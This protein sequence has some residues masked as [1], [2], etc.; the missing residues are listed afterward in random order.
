MS[1]P[2]ST[3]RAYL[4]VAPVKETNLDSASPDSTF[5]VETVPIDLVNLKEG[6]I[7]VK[8]LFFSND[9][10]Q[11]GFIQKGLK[12]EDTYAIPIREGQTMSTYGLFE[13]VSSKSDKFQVGELVYGNAFWS[14]YSVISEA[15]VFNKVDPNAGL[16]L[17]YFM[18]IVGLTGLTAYFGLLKVGKITS[19]DTV[20]ISAASGATGSNAV[21]FAKKIFGAKKVVGITGTDEK[22]RAVEALGADVGLNYNDKDFAEKLAAATDKKI[23]LYYDNVGGSILNT[24]LRS[25]SMWG[26]V[27][28][29]GSIAAYNDTSANVFSNWGAVTVKRLTVTGFIVI[30]FKENFGEAIQAIIGG[31]KAGTIKYEHGKPID[32]VGHFE[33]VPETW[34]LLFDSSKKPFGKLISKIAEL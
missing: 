7:G 19:E 5:K 14:E 9:P 27:V 20:V 8:S 11:R 18:D 4:A 33:K 12:P 31:L 25:M 16:P 22:A 1:L 15:S 34:G 32:L 24:V 30:D 3:K 28:A 10:T 2:T 13:V 29:C 23:D 26:R 6:Q 21:Q 17:H